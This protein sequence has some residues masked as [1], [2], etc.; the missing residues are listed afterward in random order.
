LVPDTT[1]FNLE[2]EDE[3]WRLYLLENGWDSQM[4]DGT[5]ATHKASEMITEEDGKMKL[6]RDSRDS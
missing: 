5:V 2:E 1:K 3:K 6:D 4:G